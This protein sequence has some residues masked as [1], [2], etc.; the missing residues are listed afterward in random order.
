MDKTANCHYGDRQRLAFD[1]A[2]TVNR[3]MLALIDAECHH[4]Q[5]E[6]PLFA[7][8]VDDALAFGLEGIERCLHSVPPE[9][10]RAVNICCD[11][12]NHL[13]DKD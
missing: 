7:H 8:E 2:E 4:I 1:L 3:E 10:T 9:V 6:E 5:L 11:Y 12:P 13:D